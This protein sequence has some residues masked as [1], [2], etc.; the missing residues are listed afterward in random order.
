MQ[1]LAIATYPMYRG[2]AKVLGM[3]VKDVPKDYDESIRILKD[4]YNDYQFFFFHVKETDLAGEDGNFPEKIKAIENADKL[5]PQIMEL[6]P[7]VLYN[8]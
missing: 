3:D 6:N 4:N 1:A 8:R 2:I 7:Q 5:I